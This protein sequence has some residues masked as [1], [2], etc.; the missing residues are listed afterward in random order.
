MGR[1]RSFADTRAKG[2][3]A[4]IPAVRQT[5]IEARESTFSDPLGGVKASPAP[6]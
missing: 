4:P 2:E 6:V 1:T 3:D 5:L